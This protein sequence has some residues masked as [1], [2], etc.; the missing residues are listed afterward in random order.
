MRFTLAPHITVTRTESGMV[1]L[2]T[3]AG[4]LFELNDTAA[5]IVEMLAG[6][7]STNEVRQQLAARAGQERS[8]RDVAEF[9]TMLV[10][11]GLVQ[12]Q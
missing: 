12:A 4:R 6:G 2:D 9:V 8:G 3:D 11:R 5:V 10:E 1:L 7:A